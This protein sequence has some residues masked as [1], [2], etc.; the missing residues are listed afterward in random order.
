MTSAAAFSLRRA[1][2][3]DAR[4]ILDCL[5]SAFEPY[6]DA[7]TPEAFRDTVMTAET[8]Q[9][10]FADMSL[11][12]AV[13]ATGEIVGSLGY[14]AVGD[15]E[16]HIRGMAVRPD[17]MGWGVGQALLET[18]EAELRQRGCARISLDT[19]APLRRAIRFYERNGFQFSGKV[20]DFFGMP[21]FEYI[22]TL[23]RLA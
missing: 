22:K 23:T 11:F 7:Y 19:T 17:Y 4:G 2:P 21:L 14:K 1:T 12:V 6:R 20:R 5:R 10:R 13:S 9:Q 16:G 8:L 15:N 18:V 3:G